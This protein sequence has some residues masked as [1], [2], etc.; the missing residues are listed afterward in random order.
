MNICEQIVSNKYIKKINPGQNGP[1]HN[2]P[3]FENIGHND[4]GQ[5]TLKIK[6]DKIYKYPT[7]QIEIQ[8]F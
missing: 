8:L 3:N 6:L 4:A 7:I 5:N 2:G 1:G